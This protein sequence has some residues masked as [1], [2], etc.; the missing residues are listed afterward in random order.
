MELL[1][2]ERAA[3][4][5]ATIDD[6][7][8]FGA[9][10]LFEEPLHVGRPNI[11]DRARLHERIDAMLDRRWLTNH[12]ALVQE[13]EQ[14]LARYLGVRHAV[15]ICNGTV[16]L[17][18]A[19]RALGLAGEVIVPSFTFVATAHA[20]QGQGIRPVFVDLDPRTHNLDPEAVEAAITPRTSGILGVHLW[21]R[22]APVEALSALA[23]RHGLRLLFDAAH[24]FGATHGGRP[25]GNFGDC[26]VFSFHATKVFNTFE[27]GAICTNNDELA[28]KIRLM[29]NFGFQ[30]FDNVVY[31]GTNGKMSEVCA[32]MGL[33]NLEALNTFLAANRAN[34]EAYREGLAGLPGIQLVQYDEGERGNY[35]YV[36]AELEAAAFGLPRDLVYEMLHAERVMARRYF[37]PGCHR[38]E[39]YR[40]TQPDA[41]RRLPRTEALCERVL[42]FPTGTQVGDGEIAAICR[43]LRFLHRE[44]QGIRGAWA[45]QMAVG[46]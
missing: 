34:Y 31:L 43:L 8:Y 44:A 22:P 25:I 11:G 35:Q 42:A 1:L 16:A 23:R 29:K 19:V 5:L 18:L 6:L 36:V 45:C 33:C 7:A 2:P 14:K 41:G 13:F 26:E 32:A 3:K 10:P 27:G 21:G 17:E 30:G 28:A 37:S 12:G 46:D 9:P 39:P 24:A 15:P 20:L 40:T 38:M 4:R